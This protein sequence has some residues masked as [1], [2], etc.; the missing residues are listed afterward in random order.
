MKNTIRTSA[1]SISTV[2][3]TQRKLLPLA[4]IVKNPTML[5]Q[6]MHIKVLLAF[7]ANFKNTSVI[8]IAL[9]LSALTGTSE[10]ESEKQC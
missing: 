9:A 2:L 10:T 5:V 7:D 1:P 6:N 3:I 8:S 4:K